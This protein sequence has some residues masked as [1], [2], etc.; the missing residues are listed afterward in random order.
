[1]SLR[2]S[3][4]G[5]VPL[6]CMVSGFAAAAPVH[7]STVVLGGTGQP[8]YFEQAIDKLADTFQADGVKVKTLSGDTRARTALL[9]EMKSSGYRNLLYVTLHQPRENPADASRGDV[10][11]ECYVDAKKV[12]VETARGPLL[13]RG[14]KEGEVKH[15]LDSMVEKVGKRVRSAC[16]SK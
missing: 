4:A 10:S 16:L 8:P 5:V 15:M 13:L 9:E 6:L 1:M 14:S 11:V 2:L 7:D 3:S 12:W